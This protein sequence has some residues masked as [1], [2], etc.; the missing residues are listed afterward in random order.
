MFGTIKKFLDRLLE[1]LV[2]L[3]MGVLVLDVLWQVFSRLVIKNPSKWTE[4]LAVFMLIWV[5]LLGAAIALGRGA[6]LGIDYFVAKLPSK[7]KTVTEIGV[8]LLIALFSFFVMIIGGIDLVSSTLQLNQTSPA[9]NVKIGLVYIAVPI[10]GFFL[11]LYSVIALFERITGK[12]KGMISSPADTANEP[13]I[14]I[15]EELTT[16]RNIP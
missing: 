1:S 8:F 9:L 6:H 16:E 3:V 4:E 13:E 14:I 12:S 2:I 10:S 15:P 7:L 11:V 5:S